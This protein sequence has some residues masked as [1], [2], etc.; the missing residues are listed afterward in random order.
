MNKTYLDIF[1]TPISGEHKFVERKINLTWEAEAFKNKTLEIQLNFDNA[2]DIS[3][4]DQYDNITFQIINQT[5][6]FSSL[7]GNGLD[8]ES[9][10]LTKKIKKQMINTEAGKMIL[11]T[12]KGAKSM[13]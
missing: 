6:I 11:A 13:I 10:N 5:D 12:T 2:L 8:F 3:S 7:S 1:I 9:K 4:L